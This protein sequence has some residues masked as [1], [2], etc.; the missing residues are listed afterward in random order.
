MSKYKKYIPRKS[1]SDNLAVLKGATE[2]LKVDKDEIER[3]LIALRKNSET[4]VSQADKTSSIYIRI[5]RDHALKFYKTSSYEDFY[6]LILKHFSDVG[7]LLPNT[8][9][10]FL[11]G[12][13][14]YKGE[15]ANKSYAPTC[16]ASI[17][18]PEDIDID[19]LDIDKTISIVYRDYGSG[20]SIVT[21]L[22]RPK[23]SKGD[24]VVLMG[25]LDSAN[26][27]LSE[28]EVDLLK[29]INVA[30]YEFYTYF[31]GYYKAQRHLQMTIKKKRNRNSSESYISL[32][33]IFLFLTILVIYMYFIAR[34]KVA[35]RM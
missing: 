5:I 19:I 26:S 8:I 23:N 31:N 18:S 32:I 24:I 3:M 6:K 12:R 7:I 22:L 35:K 30:N 9:S 17:P 11:I 25:D 20:K 15:F 1:I 29:S 14:L 28:S 34:L 2:A 16:I 21:T 4:L 27:K 13:G 10:S 33:A